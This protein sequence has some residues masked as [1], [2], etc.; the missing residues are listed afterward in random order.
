VTVDPTGSA[1]RRKGVR[2]R[3][4]AVVVVV[5]ALVA[6][7][8]AF[9]FGRGTAAARVTASSAAPG[10]DLQS[11]VGGTPG[12]GHWR[13]A[14]TDPNPTVTVGLSAEQKVD[15][16]EVGAPS[17]GTGLQRGHL[18]FS[19]GSAVA[20]GAAGRKGV[21]VTFP[22]RSSSFVR[23]VA[24]SF[25]RGSAHVEYTSIS[26]RD[27]PRVAVAPAGRADE[28]AVSSGD[29]SEP[30]DGTADL[31]DWRPAA[32]DQHPWARLTWRSDREVHLLSVRARNGD[33]TFTGSV[34]FSDGSR[35]DLGR[36]PRRSGRR[37]PSCPGSPGP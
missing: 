24:D 26:I 33:A 12:A 27:D 37:P 30:A 3:V 9:A 4:V 18:E 2:V 28:V 16:V 5:L 6:G 17:A 34:T 19:D 31:Q 29:R 36:S 1:P 10:S 7:G 15:R 20:F 13:S 25:R 14:D 22:S 21:V 8:A 35:L 32:D 23:I 11:L